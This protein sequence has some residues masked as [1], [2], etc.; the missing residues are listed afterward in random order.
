MQ[1]CYRYQERFHFIHV[2]IHF[3]MR[4]QTKLLFTWHSGVGKQE[5]CLYGDLMSWIS[6]CL[7]GIVWW[8]R[9]CLYTIIKFG[10]PTSLVK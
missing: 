6:I 3:K 4:L 1:L 5:I 2:N 8:T 9:I 7:H 10:T